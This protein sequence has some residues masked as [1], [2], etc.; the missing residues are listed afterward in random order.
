MRPSAA[1]RPW[2]LCLSGAGSQWFPR[3]PGD[4]PENSAVLARDRSE[5]LGMCEP[6]G[7]RAGAIRASVQPVL[8]SG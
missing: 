1:I 2:T 8:Q 6:Q 7:A 5:L 4:D 3:S